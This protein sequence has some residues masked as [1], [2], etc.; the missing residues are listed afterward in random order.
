[1]YELFLN[2]V[3][4]LYNIIN[5]PIDRI[6]KTMAIENYKKTLNLGKEKFSEIYISLK[7]KDKKK[8]KGVV[9]TPK[10]ISAYMLENVLSKED[11]IKNPY[12]KIL[13]P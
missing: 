11:V 9:Y 3:N 1:M 13:D 2:K 8:E 6:F 12:I 4:E 7:E 5:A 10:E